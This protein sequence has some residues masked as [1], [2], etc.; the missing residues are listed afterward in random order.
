MLRYGLVT[1]LMLSVASA[2]EL[3]PETLEAWDRYVLVTDAQ[4][5]TRLHPTQTFLWTDEIQNRG[6]LLRAGEVLVAPVSTHSPTRVPSGLIHHWIGAAFIPNAKLDTVL[7]VVR[8]Y[9]HYSD[10]YHPTVI[11]SKPGRQSGSEDEFSVVMMNNAFLKSALESQCASSF[12]QVDPK[13][14]YSVS[15]STRVEQIENYGAP[16]EHRLPADEGN[17]YIWRLHTISRYEERDGGVYLEV[18]ALVL[19]RDIP[20]ALRWVVDP[21]VRRVAKS[22]M[23]TSLRETQDATRTSQAVAKASPLPMTVGVRAFV[24]Q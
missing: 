14:W 5:Q 22:S 1:L 11:A 24:K 18:E 8:D 9:A 20:G 10:Y 19:S 12:V 13:R 2:A 23:V 6:Q 15:R 7:S 16:Q 4:M 3:K 17:G 21:I